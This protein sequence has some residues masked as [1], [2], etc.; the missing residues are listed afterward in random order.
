MSLCVF[1]NDPLMSYYKKGEI[2]MGYYNPKNMFNEVHVISLFDEDVEEQEIQKMAGS[3][4]LKIHKL[5]KVNL[6]NYRYFEEKITKLVQEINPNIHRSYNRLM[7]CWLATKTA[8]KL[9]IQLVV[10][11]YITYAQQRVFL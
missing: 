9:H 1:P 7:Q 5:G 3:A 8:N 2:K 4:T 10:Y 6:A 11:L